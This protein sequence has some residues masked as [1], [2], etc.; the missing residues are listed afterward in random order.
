MSDGCQTADGRN[1][2][3]GRLAEA[4]GLGYRVGMVNLYGRQLTWFD[5]SHSTFEDWISS[6]DKWGR[7]EL[8][9]GLHYL[10]LN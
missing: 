5:P 3:L 10:I 2:W 8:Y 1:F 6:H 4:T 9:Q 7:T